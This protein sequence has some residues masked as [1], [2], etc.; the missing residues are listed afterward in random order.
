MALQTYY[1]FS[2]KTNFQEIAHVY[3]KLKPSRE[4]IFSL[5]CNVLEEF[6]SSAAVM[7]V[8]MLPR[9]ED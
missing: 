7:K 2:S 3:S 5:T 6:E 4:Y 8:K 1:A 9:G